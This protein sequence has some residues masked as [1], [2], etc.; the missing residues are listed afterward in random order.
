MMDLLRLADK[1]S[2]E[3]HCLQCSRQKGVVF[4]TDK[5]GAFLMAMFPGLNA[6]TDWVGMSL[7]DNKRITEQILK[8]LAAPA[9]PGA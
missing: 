9:A 3:A 8:C 6:M 1:S 7:D 2:H 5:V 4:E